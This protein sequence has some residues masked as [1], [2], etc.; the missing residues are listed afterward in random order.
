MN[1]PSSCTSS[2][3]G[4]VAIRLWNVPPASTCVGSLRAAHIGRLVSLAGTV[5]RATGVKPLVTSLEFECGKCGGVASARFP[6]GRA[7]PPLGC[8]A[9]LGCKGKAPM[10]RLHSA[11]L[12]DWQRLRLQEAAG[13]SAAEAAGAGPAL[14]AAPGT[15]PPSVDVDVTADLV[16]VAGPGE[17]VTIVGIVRVA[18]VS[19]TG[20][21][22][23][24]GKG[25]G[26]GV[27]VLSVDA[28]SIVPAARAAG[29]P[30]PP[31]PST[32]TAWAGAAAGAAGGDGDPPHDCPPEAASFSRRDLRFV[33][34]LLAETQGAPFRHLVHALAPAIHGNELVKA[35]L[36]LALFGG[37]GGA[38][39]AARA[40]GGARG[41]PRRSDIHVLLCGDAGLGKSQMLSAAASASPRGL[42]VCGSGGSAAGLTASVGRD[43][44]TGAATLDAGALALADRGAAAVDELDKLAADHEALLGVMEEQEVTVAKAGVVAR[45]PARTALLAAANPAGGAYDARRT[46]ADNVRLSPALLSR[47]DLVFL[48]AD[49]A[50][51]ATDAALSAHV[52]A[53]AAG[54]PARAAATAAALAARAAAADD[55]DGWGGLPC[56]SQGGDGQRTRPPLGEQLK[57]RA[58]ADADP[59][60][61]PL[62]RVYVAYARAHCHPTLSPEAADALR[63]TYSDLRAT[64]AVDV[65]GLAVTPRTLESL[66][67]LAEA[68]ARADLRDVVTVDD[69]SDAAD[70]L[71][72]AVA[73]GGGAAW[74]GGASAPAGRRT[75]ARAEADRLLAA[76]VARS[77]TRGAGA[78]WTAGELCGLA[79]DLD[80]DVPDVPALLDALND[81]GELLK[82]GG[83][84]YE[85]VRAR[86]VVDKAGGGGARGWRRDDENSD[87]AAGGW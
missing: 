21:G 48:L 17:M 24:G 43:A 50:D 56:Q 35:A 11:V 45:L 58:A 39:A 42:Y 16:D 64:A 55:A 62:F 80:L 47:F 59:V 34:R 40:R 70:L 15:L 4:P 76:A 23:G 12:V 85:V 52:L 9:T 60:P 51:A 38:R 36:V 31:P 32:D 44:L 83:G 22:G 54:G 3:P 69:A 33:A 13:G 81:A 65:N 63:A 74:G 8:I 87:P 20:G 30:P 72:A 26:A 86:R 57:A 79:D 77:K 25:G 14:R 37:V 7:A 71:A 18:P 6:D 41:P 10:P 75:S 82:R 67:R 29:P 68:R 49:R 61:H 28:V 84:V 78:S 1:D 53:L 2:P 27:H 66:V 19:E 46:L 5:V 73:G